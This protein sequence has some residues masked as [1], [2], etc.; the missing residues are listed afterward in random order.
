MEKSKTTS[1]GWAIP[2]DLL[3]RTDLD[4]AEKILIAIMGRL[5]ALEKPIY[6]RHQWLALKMG[7]PIKQVS[8][9][10][11]KLQNKGIVKYEG[12]KWK[13]RQYSLTEV[14]TGQIVHPEKQTSLDKLSTHKKEIQSNILSTNN[15]IYSSYKL[16]EKKDK[17]LTPSEEMKLFTT[18]D[19]FFDKVVG[20]ISEKFNQTLND[21]REMLNDFKGYWTEKNKSGTKQRWEL[22]KTFELN[23][24][25][26]T[27]IRNT[28]QFG[29][30]DKGKKEIL[31][32][33]PPEELKKYQQ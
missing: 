18:N 24:R 11:K 12:R 19:E 27:W 25:I 8:R 30:R 33:I 20:Y 32:A 6:P 7:I 9:T 10:L 31:I 23:R 22:E 14:M 26:G 5:G 16:V 21:T 2:D 3:E 13:I 15:Y 4:L 28:K 29:P 1:W 17:K